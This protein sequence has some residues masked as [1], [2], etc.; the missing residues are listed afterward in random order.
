[1]TN[2]LVESIIPPPKL[3]INNNI[4]LQRYPD[5]D[6]I[7][8]KKAASKYYKLDKNKIAVGSGVDS[9]ILLSTITLGDNILLCCPLFEVYEKCL[10]SLE[11]KYQKINFGPY[12]NISSEKIIKKMYRDTK[13]IILASPNNPTGNIVNRKEIKKILSSTSSNLVIDEAYAE[14]AGI[15]NLDLIKKYD[16]LIIFR[17][18]SKSFSLAGIRV[19]FAFANEKIISKIEK[20]R[21][22][23]QPFIIPTLSEDIAIKALKQKKYPDKN[24]YE[25]EKRKKWFIKKLRES[26]NIKIYPSKTNFLLIKTLD[27]KIRY[28]L[29]SLNMDNCQKYGLSKNFFRIPLK[30]IKFLN[31]FLKVIS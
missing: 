1:M 14:I 23:I 27:N 20:T 11:K 16:N 8:L 7:N 2:K 5:K 25:T 12:Y 30:D 9:I 18:L 3:K 13:L 29:E 6:Y 10:K 22:N 28:K 26:K 21:K 17:S 19:G 4:N 31:T 15:S 24:K